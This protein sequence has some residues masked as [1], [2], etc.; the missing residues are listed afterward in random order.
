M[1]F[2]TGFMLVSPVSHTCWRKRYRIWVCTLAYQRPGRPASPWQPRSSKCSFFVQEGVGSRKTFRIRPS[3]VSRKG[4]SP[5]PN[6][7]QRQKHTTRLSHLSILCQQGWLPHRV[8][9]R[10]AHTLSKMLCTTHT[11]VHLTVFASSTLR[12]L[13]VCFADATMGSQ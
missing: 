6:R 11:G 9:T 4:L 12:A 2:H 13:S 8:I 10:S 7:T 5:C 1:R 3:T